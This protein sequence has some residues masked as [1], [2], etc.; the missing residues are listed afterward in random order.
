MEDPDVDGRVILKWF[1]KICDR[2]TGLDLSGT[3]QGQ[4]AS[5]CEYGNE[6]SG[7]IK[8][9]KFLGQLRTNWLLQKDSAP[10]HK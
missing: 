9:G 4:V 8:C 7:F 6:P 3:G 5:S 10:V 1:F 2:G